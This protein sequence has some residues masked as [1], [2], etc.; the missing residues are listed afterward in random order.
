MKRESWQAFAGAMR[1]FLILAV[2]IAVPTTI[3]ILTSPAIGTEEIVSA[4]KRPA[5]PPARILTLGNIA[6]AG[7]LMIPI[8]G[9]TA[10]FLAYAGARRR[11]YA[12]MTLLQL[13][14][15]VTVAAGLI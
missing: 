2:V 7:F 3:L 15:F 8:V 9:Y 4:W 5:T 6:I 13:V 10:A 1:G 12:V 11:P 14:I